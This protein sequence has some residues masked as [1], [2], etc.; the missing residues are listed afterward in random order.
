MIMKLLI[1]LCLLPLVYCGEHPNLIGEFEAKD[2]AFCKVLKLDMGAGNHAAAI[3]CSCNNSAGKA[4]AYSCSYYY[5]GDFDT[6][7]PEKVHQ[8]TISDL[9]GE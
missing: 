7:I 6:C 9:K 3:E 2:G 5:S 8:E 1:L 4:K